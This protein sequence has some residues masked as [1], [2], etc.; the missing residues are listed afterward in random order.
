LRQLRILGILLGLD[1]ATLLDLR[2]IKKYIQNT[3]L[4]DPALYI[5]NI[6][7]RRPQLRV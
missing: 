7:M 4:L 2:N 5:V 1:Q 3:N 6:V